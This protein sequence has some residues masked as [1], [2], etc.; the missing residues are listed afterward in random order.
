MQFDCLWVVVDVFEV[1]VDGFWIFRDGC[2]SF[3]LLVT[4]I[5]RQGFWIF[6]WLR[7][8]LDSE[9]GFRT[10]CRNISHKQKSFSGLES[11]RWGNHRKLSFICLFERAKAGT[12]SKR[13]RPAFAR[14]PSSLVYHEEIKRNWGK[15]Q[16]IM[17]A[18]SS[19][20]WRRYTKFK[21]WNAC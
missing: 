5:S 18:F 1:V 14:L 19:L 9:D 20:R 4:T 15:V 21:S 7:L 16:G 2:R 17:P 3:L 12:T 11:P 13:L 6:N 10:G 8:S